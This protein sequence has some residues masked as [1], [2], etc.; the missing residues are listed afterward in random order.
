MNGNFEGAKATGGAA[1]PD[2]DGIDR[3]GFLKCMAWAGTGLIWSFA[4]GVPVSRVFGESHPPA[5]LADSAQ[6][7]R[8]F[9]MPGGVRHRKAFNVE[10]W[11]S[12][13]LR[14]F[15]IGDAEPAA[16]VQLSE[17]LKAVN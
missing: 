11:E 6:M 10:T 17:L 2:S 8:A 12:A 14:F 4:G 1:A 5:K 15:V 3:R 9:A 13:G 7:D 16:I